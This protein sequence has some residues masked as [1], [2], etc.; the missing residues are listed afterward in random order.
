LA[1]GTPSLKGKL[2]DGKNTLGLAWG[3]TYAEIKGGSANDRFYASTYSS[4]VDGGAGQDT[5]YLQ[6]SA[7][8]WTQAAG[9][10]GATTYTHKTTGAVITA[11]GF[12]AVAYYSATAAA[13]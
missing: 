6:G 2:F 1:N 11:R 4:T 7:K 8:L 13:V 5:L 10:G 9:N 3:S 12:E